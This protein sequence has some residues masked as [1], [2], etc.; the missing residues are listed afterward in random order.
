MQRVNMFLSL[1]QLAALKALSQKTGITYSELVRRA[2][3]RFLKTQ[4]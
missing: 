3:D 1:Q 2:I 4:K